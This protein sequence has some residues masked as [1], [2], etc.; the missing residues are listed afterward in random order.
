MLSESRDE[1]LLKNISESEGS[2]V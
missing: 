1:P 2:K